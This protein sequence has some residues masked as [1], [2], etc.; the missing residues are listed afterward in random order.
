M[1]RSLRTSLLISPNKMEWLSDQVS[2]W[3][4]SSDSGQGPEASNRAEGHGQT[5]LSRDQLLH[6]FDVGQKQLACP[7]FRQKLKDAQLLQQVGL[8]SNPFGE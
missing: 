7:D 4:P 5:D 2:A 1:I 3:W 6:F 8:P